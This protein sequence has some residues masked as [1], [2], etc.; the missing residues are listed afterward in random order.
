MPPNVR[1]ILSP[2]I[3]VNNEP[4]RDILNGIEICGKHIVVIVDNGHYHWIYPVI[5]ERVRGRNFNSQGTAMAVA[6]EILV[7]EYD[8]ILLT[9]EQWKK[10]G[11]LV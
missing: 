9:E 4:A 1:P 2:W 6:D 8:A 3:F 10:I 7:D 11:V 5:S